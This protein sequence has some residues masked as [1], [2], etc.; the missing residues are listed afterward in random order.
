MDA[1]SDKDPIENIFQSV[2]KKGEVYPV[3]PP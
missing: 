1:G 2:V 3:G